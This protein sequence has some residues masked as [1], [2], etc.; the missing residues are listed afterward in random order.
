M[1]EVA[2]MNVQKA[3]TVLLLLGI[4]VSSGWGLPQCSVEAASV[5]TIVLR[6]GDPFMQVDTA[7]VSIDTTGAVP[8]IVQGRTMLPVRAIVEAL[9]G[10]VSWD[11]ARRAVGIVLGAKTLDLVIGKPFATVN[12]APLAIDPANTHVA[13][14]IVRGR[15][16]LPVRFVG[17]Q[18]GATIDWEPVNQTVTLAFGETAATP[19]AAPLLTTP[20]DGS[21]ST[22]TIPSLAQTVEVHVRY[23]G[24]D[25]STIHIKAGARVTWVIWGDEVSSCTNRIVV[26][27][28]SISQ[29]LASGRNVI[30]FTAPPA[31]GT[32]PFA[33]WMNMVRGQFIVDP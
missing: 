30:T 12:G 11:A 2:H 31:A 14:L 18:L 8:V 3:V 33:C 24:W 6:V 32:L 22:D 25:P 26:P 7:R 23:T 20:G 28:L 19:P 1:T 9:G 15:T 10:S 29:S 5:K 21:S 13:P 27:S 16:M 17:E 4:V